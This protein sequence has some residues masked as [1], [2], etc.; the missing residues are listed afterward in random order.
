MTEIYSGKVK[1]VEVLDE[2]RVRITFTD[3]IS[4][5]DGAKLDLLEGKGKLNLDLSHHLLGTLHKAGIPQH[6]LER[7]S[8]TSIIAR[9]L[10]ILPLEV[11]V[12]NISAGSFCRRYG[13]EEGEELISPLVEF[14][15]KDDA[16]HDPL[17]D[18]NIAVLK[19]LVTKRDRDLMQVY[20][21][22]VNSVIKTYFEKAGMLLVDFKIELGIDHNGVLFVADELSADSMRV[23]DSE[24]REKLDKDRFRKD[25]GDVLQGYKSILDR[26]EKIEYKPE[27]QTLKA[28]LHI[29]P[30]GGVKNPAGGVIQRTLNNLKVPGILSVSTGKT[31]TIKIENPEETSWIQR[32]DD[33]STQ[34]L[35]NPL[36]ERYDLSFSY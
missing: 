30:K 16:L 26:L 4:A 31:I 33:A 17:I 10:K 3:K 27:K 24:T 15:V 35:S 9:K 32:I 11:V 28:I 25:L 22:Q 2:E 5:G 29:F 18:S 21:L 19:G 14:F 8:D 1:T 34:I 13:F 12:R 23:W 36:I 7:D 6:T 20:A